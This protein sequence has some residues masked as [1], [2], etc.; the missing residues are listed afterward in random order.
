MTS[1]LELDEIVLPEDTHK[2]KASLPKKEWM[3]L[4]YSNH[5]LIKPV[6]D[7]VIKNSAIK[8]PIQK[9][10]TKQPPKLSDQIVK[11]LTELYF[12]DDIEK[13]EK[14]LK[15]DLAEWK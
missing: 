13:L 10:F 5:Y 7:F 1:F 2:N 4:L 8:K 6:R 3:K 15:I 9:L 14:L 12:K 11:E